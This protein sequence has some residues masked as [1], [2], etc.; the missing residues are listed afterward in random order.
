MSL[1]MGLCMS[2]N[3]WWY[4]VN[5]L[6]LIPGPTSITLLSEPIQQLHITF[7]RFQPILTSLTEALDNHIVMTTVFSTL[8]GIIVSSHGYAALHHLWYRVQSLCLSADTQN[9]RYKSSMAVTNLGWAG[10]GI[11]WNPACYC[12]MGNCS[13]LLGQDVMEVV[14]LFQLWLHVL[15]QSSVAISYDYLHFSILYFQNGMNPEC[16]SVVTQYSKWWS[17]EHE[18]GMPGAEKDCELLDNGN[19]MC[20]HFC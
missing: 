9:C 5:A 16:K 3:L 17:F 15:I 1:N 19:S 11:S 6:L 14:Q 8:L 18:V 7:Y 4:P 12:C 13:M 20:M 2:K 10:H